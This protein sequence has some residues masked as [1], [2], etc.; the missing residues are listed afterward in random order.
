MERKILQ[1]RISVR[2][3]ISPQNP[4]CK[5]DWVVALDFF[6]QDFSFFQSVQNAAKSKTSTASDFLNF[7]FARLISTLKT[8][9]IER[10]LEGKMMPK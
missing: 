1:D 6:G 7:L 10:K 2:P 8:L 9:P 5:I 4:N 3:L